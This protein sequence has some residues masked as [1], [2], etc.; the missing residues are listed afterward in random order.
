MVET[1]KGDMLF[2]GSILLDSSFRVNFV[3]GSPTK[4]K[5]FLATVKISS[6]ENSEYLKTLKDME[7]TD[8]NLLSPYFDKL[9]ISIEKEFAIQ[10]TVFNSL[11]YGGRFDD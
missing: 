8:S 4:Q 11:E 6:M 7:L 5:D 2:N 10:S 3:S 9:V 1:S